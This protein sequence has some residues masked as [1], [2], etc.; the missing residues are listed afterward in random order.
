MFL[1]SFPTSSW[2]IVMGGSRITALLDPGSAFL[3]LSP[4]AGHLL[5]PGED[6][7]AGGIIT[8]IGRVSGVECMVVANDS[9]YV[10]PPLL[11]SCLLLTTRVVVLKE[12]CRVK[13][14]TYYPIT[15][16]KHI[17]A[18]AIAQENSQFSSPTPFAHYFSGCSIAHPSV[19]LGLPCIYLVDSGGANL[20]HQADVFPD[21]DHFGRIFYNQA[22]ST[23]PI[24]SFLPSK[25]K[26]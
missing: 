9:T 23:P 19:E 5:Y 18:Q 12:R 2:R 24:P 15:V 11:P 10:F 25:T 26:L 20:P 22:R 8:G 16:K 21:R 1:P 3:E 6:V 13:G 7:P 14:G 4:L 17:R